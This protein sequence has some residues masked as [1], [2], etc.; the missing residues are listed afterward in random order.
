[1]MSRIARNWHV[2]LPL[3]GLFEAPTIADV[4]AAIQ[5]APKSNGAAAEA[6]PIP[7]ARRMRRDSPKQPDPR[8]TS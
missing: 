1:M 4:A 7:V 6:A 3:R 8:P 5:A 2:N